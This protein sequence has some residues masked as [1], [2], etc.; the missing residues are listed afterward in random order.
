MIWDAAARREEGGGGRGGDELPGRP[1]FTWCVVAGQGYARTMC[2]KSPLLV[3]L[4][5]NY[6]VQDVAV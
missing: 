2:Q 3:G 6:S 4:H 5:V 1:W